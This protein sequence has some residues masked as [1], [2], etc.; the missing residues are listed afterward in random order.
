ML[1]YRI[2]TSSSE[3]SSF[4]AINPEKQAN[5]VKSALSLIFSVYFCCHG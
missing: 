2:L 4:H 3:N 5:A 1:S